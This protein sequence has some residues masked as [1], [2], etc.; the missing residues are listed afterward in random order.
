MRNLAQATPEWRR[1]RGGLRSRSGTE[2]HRSG[3][4][5]LEIQVVGGGDVK[6]KGEDGS[7]CYF[8]EANNL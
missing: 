8:I 5:M 7:Y 4:N 1:L 2:E 6:G 3:G